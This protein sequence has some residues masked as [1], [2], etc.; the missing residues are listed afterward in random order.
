MIID[1]AAQP[2]RH[3]HL[4][5]GRPRAAREE[6]HED[7]LARPGGA[8]G[9]PHDEDPQGRPRRRCSPART[10]ASRAACIEARP[11][12]QRVIVENLNIVKRHTKPRPMR[13]ANRMGGTQM[14]PGGVIE[15]PAPLPVVEGDGRLPDVQPADAGRRR[16]SSEV[17]GKTVQGARLQAATAADGRSTS[18]RER[19]HGYAPRLKERYE[20]EI[21][22]AAEGRARAVLGHAGAAAYEDHPEHGR[23]RGEDR[24]E[25]ARQR[26]SRS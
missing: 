26:R 9:W 12:E 23:R 15:K 7:R 11:R 3:P 1:A 18:E 8:L 4:R 17:K 6:L 13:D 19:R 16:R 25:G 24:R 14:M 5:P 2:A 22:A 21:R 10:A 20:E